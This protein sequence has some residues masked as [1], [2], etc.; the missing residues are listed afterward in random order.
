MAKRRAQRKSKTRRRRAN[1]HGS[2][3]S[4]TLLRLKKLKAP[5]R[6]EAMKI[7]NDKFIRDFTTHIKKLRQAKGIRPS[8]QKKLKRH[9]KA[10]RMLTNKKTSIKMKRNILSQ[11]GGFLPLLLAALPAIGSIVGGII[12]RT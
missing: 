11:R 8:L 12:S 5:Q 7:A 2:K 4:T 10:L 9:S 6:H 3:F 1:K